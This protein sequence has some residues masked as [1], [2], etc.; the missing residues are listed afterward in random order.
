MPNNK[1]MY[2]MRKSDVFV[3]HSVTAKNGDQEGAPVAISEAMALGLPV[4]ST[5]HSGIPCMIKNE[6]TGFLVREHD[7]EA[8]TET[9]KVTI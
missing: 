5:K 3:Q 7:K 2:E 9:Y 1:V 4:I 6:T 8:L